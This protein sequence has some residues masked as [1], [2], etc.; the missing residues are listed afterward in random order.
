M[1]CGI[2]LGSRHVKMVLADEAG[3]QSF[4]T[5]D[6]IDFYKKYGQKSG[7]T[8]L[9]D[10]DRLG[11]KNMNFSLDERDK[12]VTTGYGRN[13]IKIAGGEDIPEIKAH[14]LGAVWQT[15][16]KD[17]T[18]LD[19]G[20]QDSKVV[21]VRNGK[22]ADFQTNDKCAA[23]SGRYLENMADILGIDIEELSSHKESPVELSSTCA[24]FGESE[25]IGKIIEG[26]TVEALAAGVNYTVFKRVKPMLA[27]LFSPVIVFT[28]GVAK[29][30][31][32][33]EILRKEMGSEIIVPKYPQFNGAIGC[34]V[35]AGLKEE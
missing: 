3:L 15:G 34:C 28:G 1:F 25:L 21:L 12:L 31:A 20:G 2:D 22:L 33:C 18:L 24:I 17:F 29:N 6:T 23:G 16:I 13:T 5:F 10:F 8:L 7:D 27:S 26:H 32:L 11:F 19:L 14:A 35:Y 4:Q 9:V 30:K